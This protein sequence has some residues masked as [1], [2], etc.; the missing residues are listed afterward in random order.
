MESLRR[1]RFLA[2]WANVCGFA[3]ILSPRRWYLR[4]SGAS[5]LGFAMVWLVS[6]VVKVLAGTNPRGSVLYSHCRSG[7]R[8][9]ALEI[10][11]VRAESSRRQFLAEWARFVAMLIFGLRRWYSQALRSV[12]FSDVVMVAV[13][14]LLEDADGEGRCKVSL[15][16]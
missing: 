3:D 15:A 14:Q 8:H 13:Q 1:R 11:A 4:F 2:E 10:A 9:V 6:L 7:S 5:P 12:C 16:S